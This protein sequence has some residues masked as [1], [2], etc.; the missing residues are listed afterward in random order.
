MRAKDVPGELFEKIAEAKGLEPYAISLSEGVVWEVIFCK[1]SCAAIGYRENRADEGIFSFLDVWHFCFEPNFQVEDFC[2]CICKTP[3]LQIEGG[4]WYNGE[5]E[6]GRG[7]GLTENIIVRF[8]PDWAGTGFFM[9]S[10]FAR[11]S[12][13]LLKIVQSYHAI[14]KKHKYWQAS[15]R[16]N[17]DYSKQY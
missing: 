5:W 8:G 16:P 11:F 2:A 17:A 15:L 7:H 12:F 6:Q 14:I 10:P 1:S 4:P 13:K 9:D 3:S